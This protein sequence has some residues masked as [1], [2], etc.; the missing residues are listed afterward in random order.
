MGRRTTF[1]REDAVSAARDVF[2]QDGYDGASMASLQSATGLNASS[3]YHAFGSKRGLFDAAVED[4]LERVVRPGLARFHGE[5]VD[6]GALAQ[7]FGAARAILADPT[8]RVLPDGCLL[9]NTACSGLARDDGIAEAV[10]AYR[11]ELRAAFLRGA[12]ARAPH[13]PPDVHERLAET[14]VALLISA[15]VMARVDQ[16]A[17]LAALDAALSHLAAREG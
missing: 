7:Y 1:V 16:A 9:V 14:L 3:L 10:G 15:L 6:P 2:W 8:G 17:A 12:A 11:A 5:R 4:Y 13:E